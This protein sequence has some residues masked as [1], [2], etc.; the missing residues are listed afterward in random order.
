MPAL[1]FTGRQSAVDGDLLLQ[2]ELDGKPIAVRITQETIDDFGLSA[3]QNKAV[4][5]AKAGR[6]E[7]NGSILVRTTDFSPPGEPPSRT[8]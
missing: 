5:K 6:L 8:L 2:A 7:K 4:E 1:Y 3:G